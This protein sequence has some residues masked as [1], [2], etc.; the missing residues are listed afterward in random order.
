[1]DLT[2][3]N[4]T[5]EKMYILEAYESLLWIDKFNEPGTFELYTLVNDDILEY[6][7]PDYYLSCENSEHTMIIEDISIESNVEEG[8]KIKII[9]RSLESILER[10]VIWKETIFAANYNLQKAIRKLVNEALISTGTGDL[11]KRRIDNFELDSMSTDT[12]ITSL[13]LT[14]GAQYKGTTLLEAV[15]SLCTEYNI[16]FKVIL[17][18]DNKF[19][20]S[21]YNGVDRSYDQNDRPYVVFSPTFD[22]LIS[23]DYKEENSKIRNVAHVVGAEKKETNSQGEE[24]VVERPE[25]TIGTA[26][27]LERREMHVDASNISWETEEEDEE[28]HKT[29]LTKP[30]YIKLLKQKGRSELAENNKNLKSF[31]AQCDTNGLYVY[32]RDFFIGDTVQLTNEY[33]TESK[34]RITEFTWSITTSGIE[35]YPTFVS[36]EEEVES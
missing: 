4:Q 22:N 35:T 34:S 1:M 21:L 27:G 23:S 28:G 9:G 6:F 32:E 15:Q 31:D 11:A 26:S 8:D 25:T 17:S 10:R 5:F 29:E 7:K 3:M 13:V 14:D 20:F 18:D 24:E 36:V 33:G 16:G 30:E 12:S 19:I 2:V